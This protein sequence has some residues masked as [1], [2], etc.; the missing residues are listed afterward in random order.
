MLKVGLTGGIACGKSYTLK[1]FQKLG[2]YGIDSD[3]IA[4]Q[5]I[6]PHGPAFADV[7]EAFG[8]SVLDAGGRINRKALGSIVFSNPEAREKLNAIVHPHIFAEEDR[9][10]A[11]LESD[12]SN[13]RPGIA[14]VDAALTIE[15][16]S[17]KRYD[18]LIVVYCHPEIQLRRLMF[19]DGC[20]EEEALARM[21]SQMPV[22]EKLKF[23]DFVI[24]NSGKLSNTAEQIQQTY[25]ELVAIQEQSAA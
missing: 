12:L 6:S 25:A 17:Y 15:T 3:E 8:E 23:A 2:V 13:V 10:L 20:T 19:R 16:G 11:A 21:Q 18:R 22:M 1:E 7:V 4:H 5:V 24:D 9:L 14:M